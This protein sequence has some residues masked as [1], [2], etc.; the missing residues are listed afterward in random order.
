MG[1]EVSLVSSA[2]ETAAELLRT[3]ADRG[4]LAPDATVPTHEFLTTGNPSQ[5]SEL[6]RRFLGPEVSALNTH[7]LPVETDVPPT[8]SLPVLEAGDVR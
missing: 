5:F 8:G 6:A 1:P 2:E 3:L 4:E 7:R